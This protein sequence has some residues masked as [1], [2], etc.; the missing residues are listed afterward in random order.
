[1]VGVVEAGDQLSHGDR[2][3]LVELREIKAPTRR[4][5]QQDRPRQARP[6]VRRRSSNAAAKCPSAEIVPVSAL[7]GDN[8]DELV[9]VI[10]RMLPGEPGPD[11]PT[12]STP[13]RPS[14]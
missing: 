14:G 5:G 13:I 6:T 7:K 1:M 8:V 12:M 2:A 3:F 10:K 11:A 4:R 9:A